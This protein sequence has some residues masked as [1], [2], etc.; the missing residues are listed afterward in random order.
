MNQ[1]SNLDEFVGIA[2]KKLTSF[3]IVAANSAEVWSNTN[4]LM[5]LYSSHAT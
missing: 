3:V 2:Q 5:D 4:V 1:S